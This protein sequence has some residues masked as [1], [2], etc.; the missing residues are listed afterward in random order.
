MLPAA[1]GVKSMKPNS[2]SLEWSPAATSATPTKANVHSPSTMIIP[3]HLRMAAGFLLGSGAI[4]AIPPFT[5]D[6]GGS[7]TV[8]AVSSRASEVYGRTRLPNGSYQPETYAFGNG[9]FYGAPTSNDAIANESF[10]DVARV[11]AGPLA[12]QNFVPTK[13]PN[14]A[15]LLIMVYWGAT[16]GTADPYSRNF[17]PSQYD[18]HQPAGSGAFGGVVFS[19]APY[20]GTIAD[21]Q[22]AS[23]LGYDSA[24][25]DAVPHPGLI[26]Q[27]RR[28]D[29]IDDIVQSRYFVV[30]MA[31]DFQVLWK[32]KKHRLLWESRFSIREQGND[33]KKLLPAMAKYA[34]QYFGQDTQGVVRRPLPEGNVE[35]GAPQFLGTE[36]DRNDLPAETT[37]IAGP[38]IL[39]TGPR[40]ESPDLSALPEKLKGRIV[41][42]QRERTALQD[43]L[44]AMIKARAPGEDIRHAIDTFNSENSTRIASLDQDSEAI[45]G[46]LSRFAAAGQQPARGQPVE[47]LVRQFS[48]S[49]REIEGEEP[50][51][52][53]P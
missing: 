29:L 47:T 27:V 19:S 2:P 30:L 53:H 4:F 26:H 16:S 35:V 11:V 52:T 36:A 45:R 7:N 50:L 51:F 42:Y 38:G 31:Y 1:K 13:D 28:D 49:V 33:F 21:S 34:S 40:G 32:E 37:L 43:T 12:G 46:E 22:N 9:G 8:T 44:S 15:N 14:K 24:L 6:W 3:G 10:M 20:G 25:A 23:I 41:A 48:D 39:S 5:S 17:I 18:A